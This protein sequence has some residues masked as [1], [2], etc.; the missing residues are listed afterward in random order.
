VQ[1]VYVQSQRHVAL[2]A[3]NPTQVD[4]A[5]SVFEQRDETKLFY[6][7]IITGFDF[8][9]KTNKQFIQ[10][11]LENIFSDTD[12]TLVNPNSGYGPNAVWPVTELTIV[13]TASVATSATFQVGGVNVS[14]PTSET[15]NTVESAAT[16][17]RTVVGTG[18]E[19][20]S[21]NGTGACNAVNW[22][23]KCEPKYGELIAIDTTNS[24]TGTPAVNMAAGSKKIFWTEADE[25]SDADVL[26]GT[27][28]KRA[29]PCP[30]GHVCVKYKVMN[31]IHTLLRQNGT[32]AT[33]QRDDVFTYQV[34]EGGVGG[35][36]KFLAVRLPIRPV[37]HP[38]LSRRDMWRCLDYP[39]H[40]GESSRVESDTFVIE[41]YPRGQPNQKPVLDINGNAVTYIP[42]TGGDPGDQPLPGHVTEPYSDTGDA[43]G[44]TGWCNTPD[45][46][47][48]RFESTS[49]SAIGAGNISKTDATKTGI[50]SVAQDPNEPW[51]FIYKPQNPQK[52]SYRVL[53]SYRVTDCYDADS[54]ST[55]FPVD[56]QNRFY[57][58]VDVAEAENWQ[59]I[60]QHAC[61][62]LDPTKRL[63]S[64]NASILTTGEWN[65]VHIK[66]KASGS[67]ASAP[68]WCTHTI[69]IGTPAELP[70]VQTATFTIKED[71]NLGPSVYQSA[72]RGA[73]QNACEVGSTKCDYNEVD[74]ADAYVQLKRIEGKV[75]GNAIYEIINPALG[76][77]K[78]NIDGEATRTL[79]YGVR[80]DAF[81]T[82]SACWG[83]H[84][85]T[86][87]A[88]S[89][90][91]LQNEKR[92][93][94]STNYF[95]TA[96]KHIWVTTSMGR[97]RLVCS[98]GSSLSGYG[99]RGQCGLENGAGALFAYRPRA[100][101]FTYTD[102]QSDASADTF[103]FRYKTKNIL[104]ECSDALPPQG[105][106]PCVDEYIPAGTD[107]AGKTQAELDKLYKSHFDYSSDAKVIVHIQ[108]VND[109]PRV[110]Q[111]SGENKRYNEYTQADPSNPSVTSS[112]ASAN[113]G[114]H[115]AYMTDVADEAFIKDGDNFRRLEVITVQAED[116]DERGALTAYLVRLPAL[117]DG[118]GKWYRD[119]SQSRQVPVAESFETLE[120]ITELYT[121]SIKLFEADAQSFTFQ[122]RLYFRP[123]YRNRGDERSIITA[124]GAL[125]DPIEFVV[126][127]TSSDKSND[128]RTLYR[129]GAGVSKDLSPT[130]ILVGKPWWKAI[131]L[132]TTICEN[133]VQLGSEDCVNA[134][135]P[136][137]GVDHQISWGFIQVRMRCPQGQSKVVGENACVPC[138]VGQF[139]KD[140][141]SRP[142]E[143]SECDLKCT[144]CEPGSF[145]PTEGLVECPLC[146][147]NEY[148]EAPG[149]SSCD[150][151]VD[152]SE[153]MI[154]SK[155][156][157]G[158]SDRKACVCS[159][160]PEATRIDV[161][162]VDP[163]GP[164]GNLE[165]NTLPNLYAK[166]GRGY[167]GKAGIQCYE[168]P[169]PLIN[170]I[171]PATAREA[172]EGEWVRCMSENM[173]LPL[174]NLGFY[175]STIIPKDDQT[176]DELPRVI[177]VS[178]CNPRSA[179]PE[180]NSPTDLIPHFKC[181][182]GYYGNRCAMC[183]PKLECPEKGISSPGFF[184]LDSTCRKCP[185]QSSVE[186]AIVLVVLVGLFAPVLFKLADL[187][188]RAPSLNIQLNFLQVLAILPKF[189]MPWPKALR[190]MFSWFSILNF[191]LELVHP[192]CMSDRGWDWYSKWNY[193]LLTPVFV[194]GLL[195]LVLGIKATLMITRTGLSKS[196]L[197]V[198]PQVKN[199]PGPYTNFSGR[200]KHRLIRY[201]LSEFTFEDFIRETRK[202]IRVFLVFL[203]V[204]YVYLSTTAV[205]YWD[206]SKDPAS[207]KYFL[208]A[209]ST[210]QCFVTGD[211]PTCVAD[212]VCG[213]PIQ[214]LNQCPL[215]Q[216]KMRPARHTSYIARGTIAAL[217]YP[218][219]IMGLMSF[220]MRRSRK[221]LH[222][223]NVAD[224]LEPLVREFS[225]DH[226]YWVLVVNFRKL[227]LVLVMVFF[228][229]ASAQTG[230]RQAVTGLSIFLVAL[231]IHM[232]A[233]PYDT[234]MLNH[235]ESI[236]LTA[237]FYNI[238]IGMA[239][240]AKKNGKLSP[241]FA[242]FLENS[243]MVLTIMAAVAGILM[244]WVEIEPIVRQSLRERAR[245][246][247]FKRDLQN[248]KGTPP[249]LAIR[250]ALRVRD[251]F[252]R[253][254]YGPAASAM[255]SP[256][257]IRF[258]HYVVQ[259]K[260][261]G[262]PSRS[263]VRA[264][265]KL[266]FDHMRVPES[267]R[268]KYVEKNPV[269]NMLQPEIREP[270]L[271]S[272]CMEDIDE[273][274][275][276]YEVLTT[277]IAYKPRR[278]WQR[279]PTGPVL[280]SAQKLDDTTAAGRMGFAHSASQRLRNAARR[281]VD[282]DVNDLIDLDDMDALAMP[283]NMAKRTDSSEESDT[284]EK[285]RRSP[286]ASRNPFSAAGRH[287][288]RH[289]DRHSGR[290]SA[291]GSLKRGSSFNN[292]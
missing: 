128:A 269:G 95:N 80:L 217:A 184:R 262:S 85:V 205:E 194:L 177:A 11:S 259:E 111:G 79:D 50:G 145:G 275:R 40:A 176:S 151:C 273:C 133:G 88:V 115:Y 94:F 267:L 225:E 135:T 49:L 23:S 292:L 74:D 174:N 22:T 152:I 190:D 210:E 45:C 172:E 131:L 42:R 138:S 240:L 62:E 19:A 5:T 268:L 34:T 27:K 36:V 101:A 26:A 233:F 41:A 160:R 92:V 179:C 113:M 163:K 81:C 180:H 58:P 146:P 221:D 239:L 274:S 32:G 231:L 117:G 60:P 134:G 77:F 29:T 263:D 264:A 140:P 10:S 271:D 119:R 37:N 252:Y 31:N 246:R 186:S 59:F 265:I 277:A 112:M 73:T 188:R 143:G 76:R 67:N 287:S 234:L 124:D 57:K 228:S 266:L 206:C 63:S 250:T 69:N 84:G 229:E 47:G 214:D 46:A 279:A 33:G 136:V 104:A 286:A 220:M 6:H 182:D 4:G 16:A 289:S 97:V 13:L 102:A 178:Q 162:R 130:E 75:D 86:I 254:L 278:W 185:E 20:C 213:M 224:L 2:T 129:L 105:T 3:P 150:K 280:R 148:Q 114:A 121:S 288:D 15:G 108:A 258:I 249:H 204:A 187:F 201:W 106:T 219:G 28:T 175:V 21:G 118:G 116:P 66:G 291:D 56:V 1:S 189:S 284:D 141:D 109:Y 195:G 87:Q 82:S 24:A 139:R 236:T 198:N 149:R 126:F 216:I 61:T 153:G 283:I 290:H 90:T 147:A 237:S 168:C 68:L 110:T 181:K 166:G 223:P 99:N 183:T 243:A 159:G 203:K 125:K 35:T 192:E 209:Q 72:T 154:T 171:D 132:G 91:D 282:H 245:K 9:N 120:E 230:L 122:G 39:T 173:R 103:R 257:A 142:C 169:G 208:D 8:T 158:S 38:P 64:G 164:M 244:T 144:A 156:A 25:P 200:F 261:K 199:P 202:L 54:A 247:N 193:M 197:F 107:T 137:S 211:V 222:N 43:E 235:L 96:H 270:L 123:P 12:D 255:L 51:K 157:T 127:D 196:M 165:N 161:L 48:L 215:D 14:I 260:A 226:H 17:G 71:S 44:I 251:F 78:Y 276:V 212:D 98:E 52:K 7:D 53:F 253:G 281:Q 167:Y 227:V 238:F 89:S 242:T 256:A 207:G 232:Y 18:G 191:N 170:D 218:I 55:T 100:N 30:T 83:A 70:D 285:A 93:Q 272:L 241:S 248:K 155:G 65:N